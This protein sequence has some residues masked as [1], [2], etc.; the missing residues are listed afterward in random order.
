MRAGGRGGG[1]G[2]AA[3]GGEEARAEDAGARHGDADPVRRLRRHAAQARPLQRAGGGAH[4]GAAVLGERGRG[5]GRRD[6][7]VED[8]AEG[9]AGVAAFG[10]EA[11]EL[12][13]G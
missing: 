4:E 1:G 11:R 3:H 13:V 6:G 12:G 2:G 8:G 7:P 9:V 10:E 5:R